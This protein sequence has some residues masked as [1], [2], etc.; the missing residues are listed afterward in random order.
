MKKLYK[1]PEIDLLILNSKENLLFDSQEVKVYGNDNE[2]DDPFD[3][4]G[5]L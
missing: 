4:I 5:N 1:Q 3:G 2:V